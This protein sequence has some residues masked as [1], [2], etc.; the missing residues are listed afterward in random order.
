MVEWPGWRSH[1]GFSEEQSG[2]EYEEEEHWSMV[3]EKMQE[4]EETQGMQ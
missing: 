4:R 2:C 1:S 3:S